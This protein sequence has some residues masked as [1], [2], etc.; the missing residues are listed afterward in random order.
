MSVKHTVRD[1]A[2]R[3]APHFALQILSWRSQRLIMAS[4]RETGRLDASRAFIRDVGARVL[5]GP[6]KDLK[7]PE[8]IIERRNLVPKILASYED[9]LHGFVKETLSK[10]YA[11]IVNV[12]SADGYYTVGYAMRAPDTP[13]IAFDTDPWARRATRALADCNG[14]NNVTVKAM[15]TPDW[16]HENLPEDSLLLSDCEGYEFILLDPEVAPQLR[17]ATILVEIHEHNAPGAEDEICRRFAQTHQIKI[18][19]SR[20]K[21]PASY[22]ALTVVPRDMQAIVISEGRSHYIQNW[23]LL[24]P[25]THGET[26]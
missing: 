22:E 7:Y 1:L 15:C 11:A 2:I 12:G 9:E 25:K 10:G 23:L 17:T 8:A 4:E 20:E 26:S 21:D 5:S 16:L 13:V 24:T 14:A 19:T 18:A 3:I 6:F